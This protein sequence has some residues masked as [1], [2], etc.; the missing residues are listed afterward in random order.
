MDSLPPSSSRPAG[1]I[2]SAVYVRA[3]LA[4]LALLGAGQ[5]LAD[6]V[7]D[8]RK[9]IETG[10]LPKALVKVD[11]ALA[12]HPADAQMRFLKGL[13]LAEQNR[14]PEAIA[15]FSKLTE[16]FPAFPE[17]YNNL[18]VLHASTGQYDKARVALEAA[19]RTN[20]SYATAHDNLGDIYAKLASLA[21]DKAL[22][23]DSASAAP[24]SRLTMMKSLNGYALAGAGK[25]APL[26]PVAVPAPA[27]TVSAAPAKAVPLAIAQASLPPPRT[28]PATAPVPGPLPKTAPLVV[29]SAPV[30]VPPAPAVKA[31]A[32][33][34]VASAP[35]KIAAKPEPVKPEPAKPEAPKV[36][37][38]PE[39][40]ADAKAEVPAAKPVAKAEAKVDGARAEVVQMVHAWASAW[41]AQ[42]F[43][44]YLGMYAADF[45][46]PKGVT[47]SQWAEARRARIEGKRR[48]SV[49]VDG[50]Q[51]AIDGNTATVK[52]R[53]SYTSDRLTTSSGKVLVLEKR[54]A[55]WQIRQERTGS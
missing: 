17:P 55:R 5:A 7:A 2:C 40:K 18:A 1:S 9:I 20:P 4:A 48:I 37:D 3:L 8:V 6:E 35:L 29:A 45:Q 34:P 47:R 26:P 13:I 25:P 11:A 32:P 46:T 23:L 51:V 21:Y 24:T 22:Q 36:L 19:L 31:D 12:Q 30:P 14:V 10:Q 54:D 28:P 44:T 15:V 53:Q 39:K 16:D 49:R 27:G 38:K 41:S 33:K 43:K 52:F 42:E 50:V